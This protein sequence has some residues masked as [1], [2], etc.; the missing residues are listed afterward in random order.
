[1]QKVNQYSIAIKNFDEIAAT[2]VVAMSIKGS[3]M[4]ST[5]DILIIS[6]D[7]NNK[8]DKFTLGPLLPNMEKHIISSFWIPLS[9]KK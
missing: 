5:R 9:Y 6:S 3:D 4:L 1:M 7:Y 2:N 8:V